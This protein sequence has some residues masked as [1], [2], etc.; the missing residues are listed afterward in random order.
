MKWSGEQS[1]GWSNKTPKRKFTFFGGGRSGGGRGA[2]AAAPR[3]RRAPP[4][5]LAPRDPSLENFERFWTFR[6][7]RAFSGVFGRFRAFS[8][9][10]GDFRAFSDVFE[11]FCA[12]W[13]VFR[14]VLL[15]GVFWDRP[16][17]LRKLTK[18][19]NN[20]FLIGNFANLFV[21][22]GSKHKSWRIVCSQS[23]AAVWRHA[24]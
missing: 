12:F 22:P 8:N 16:S 20:N 11:S 19:P 23:L 13:D 4:S 21:F 17:L 24:W 1:D 7:F 15:L 2:T 10:F 5:E 9:V 3:R 14:Y 6:T 18:M